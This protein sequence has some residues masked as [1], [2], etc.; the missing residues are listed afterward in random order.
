MKLIEEMQ[1]QERAAEVAKEEAA[2]GGVDIL[3][4]VEEM[5]QML[6]NAKEANDMVRLR[7]LSTLSI[8]ISV[9]FSV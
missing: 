6:A 7:C 9:V 3:V 5:K 2:M 8:S 1:L 4:K